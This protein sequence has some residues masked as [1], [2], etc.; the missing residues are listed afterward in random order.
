MSTAIMSTL[1]FRIVIAAGPKEKSSEWVL[2]Q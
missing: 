2:L 1:N